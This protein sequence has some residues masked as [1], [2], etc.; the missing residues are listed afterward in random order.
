M[1]ATYTASAGTFYNVFG[2]GLPEGDRWLAIYDPDA[3]YV[4]FVSVTN[5]VPEASSGVLLVLGLL[6]SGLASRRGLRRG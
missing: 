3:L 4:Q 2:T 1:I 5:S 6:A